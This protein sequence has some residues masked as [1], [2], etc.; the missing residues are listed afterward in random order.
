MPFKRH[1][2]SL[3]DKLAGRPGTDQA[4]SSGSA[5]SI[6]QAQKL[7]TLS[8]PSPTPPAC[9]VSSKASST[10]HVQ[11]NLS[12]PAIAPA[13][14]HEESQN[15]SL[16]GGLDAPPQGATMAIKTTNHPSEELWDRA[17]ES[18]C[19]EHQKLSEHYLQVSVQCFAYFAFR[20]YS[21]SNTDFI[22]GGRSCDVG[23][24]HSRKKPSTAL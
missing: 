20:R 22:S 5:S 13:C 11:S 12:A 4:K 17:F 6:R 7:P 8:L 19:R 24:F 18:F 9:D 2:T 10:N 3:R 23:H 21:L 16:Q 1:L 15:G 14:G